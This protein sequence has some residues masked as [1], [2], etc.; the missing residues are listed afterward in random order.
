MS[1]C[2]DLCSAFKDI[3]GSAFASSARDSAYVLRDDGPG[4]VAETL[5]P[6]IASIILFALMVAA[7]GGGGLILTYVLTV[8]TRHLFRRCPDSVCDTLT[9][10]EGVRASCVNRSRGAGGTGAGA[11][12]GGPGEVLREAHRLIPIPSHRQAFLFS[13]SRQLAWT[14]TTPCCRARLRLSSARE[15]HVA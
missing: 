13:L 7:V 11:A 15:A 4:A 8:A 14:R 1:I 12:R 3:Y 5:G 2:D 6:A 10:H 9:G